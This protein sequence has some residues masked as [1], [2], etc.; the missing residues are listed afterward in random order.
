M[1]LETIRPIGLAEIRE[2]RERI[3][4]IVEAIGVHGGLAKTE[5]ALA[6]YVERAKASLA[7]LG[8]APAR[9]ELAAF[10]DALL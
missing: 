9:A 4:G 7:P 5:A 1:T 10:A 3:A 6:G 2:A 8:N